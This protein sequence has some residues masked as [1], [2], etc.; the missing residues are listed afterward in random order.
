MEIPP[1]PPGNQELA[2]AISRAGIP[3]LAEPASHSPTQRTTAPLEFLSDLFTETRDSLRLPPQLVQNL[4]PHALSTISAGEGSILSILCAA[5]LG[6]VTINKQLDTVNTRLVELSKENEQL[7][8]TIHD[9]SS[10]LANDVAT[11]VELRPLNSALR[12]LSH[13]VSAPPPPCQTLQAPSA[14]PTNV[15]LARPPPPAQSKIPSPRPH[16]LPTP[17]GNIDPSVHCPYYNTNL[18]KMFGHPELYAKAFPHSWEGSNS[19]PAS[20]T[21][22]NLPQQPNTRITNPNTSLP[23][24]KLPAPA[25]PRAE[26]E[27]R[28]PQPK[29]HNQRASP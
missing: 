4:S 11:S 27:R 22:R 9:V 13:R 3:R 20:M 7:R 29:S 25:G 21:C 18:G 26:K 14:Q 17:L 1:I 12:D 6:I 2:R 8:E 15:A 24:L 16:D 19:A 10:V 23:M 5:V 28:Q